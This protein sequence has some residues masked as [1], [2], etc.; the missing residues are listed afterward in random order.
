MNASEERFPADLQL[1]RAD[2]AACDWRGVLAGSDRDGYSSMWQAFSGAA[3]EALEKG[4]QKSSKIFWLLADA[5]S[6]IL[7]PQSKNEPFR[8]HS[9]TEA[10]RSI[11]PDDFTP[12]DIA[13][14]TA[15]VNDI[16]DAWLR[17]R[18]ADLI[19]LK[20]DVR[21]SRFALTAIDAYREI[22][23]D[24]E[25]WMRG[26]E[27]CWYRALGLAK[28]L[29]DTASDR[30]MPMED[31]II[32]AIKG[33]ASGDGFL[34]F[35]LSKLLADFQ[36]GYSASPDIAKDLRNI[37]SSCSGP[38]DFHKAREYLGAAGHWFHIA[39]DDEN[40][41]RMFMEVAENFAKEAYS[42]ETAG[43]PISALAAS[44][45]EE[46]IQACRR[47]PRRLRD[48]LGV[49]KRIS[50]VMVLL[51]SSG[52]LAIG[53][54]QTIRTPEVDITES[55][56]HARKAVSGK[57][58]IDALR[59]FTALHKGANAAR[60]RTQTL[61]NMNTYVFSRLFGSTQFGRDGRVIAKRG[62]YG[63]GGAA[64]DEETVAAEMVKDFQIEMRLV[65]QG[66]ILPALD[67]MHC[68]HRF[69]QRDFIDLARQ[70]PIVPHG[71]A[72]QFG[73]GLFAGYD[74]DFVVAIYL[75]TPQIEQLV[76]FHLQRAGAI[77]T[78]L[79]PSGIET[80]IGLSALIELP[81][82]KRVFGDDLAFEIRAVFCDAFGPNLRN[83]VAHGLLDDLECQSIYSVYAWSLALRIVFNAYWNTRQAET[84]RIPKA[85]ASAS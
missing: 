1:D 44:L 28:N 85:P 5:C 21:D 70:S 52:Q 49:Q 78:K 22:P 60:M 19:W 29:K 71:R 82:T 38:D 81:D 30:L 46:A 12:A 73:R 3:R 65:V 36:L 20:A 17:A 24:L 51:K 61:K 67:V 26:G 83:E 2:L 53:Q 77:T 25:T 18:L 39:K 54:F 4:N 32:V 23:L 66:Y 50:E 47:V 74:C 63:L 37:A 72:V 58:S 10:R 59:C 55:I 15:V 43:T 75:L 27:H 31:A 8:A 6:M 41:A 35:W 45:Y 79:D 80:E 9:T 7:Q 48:T 64:A 34:A 56:E 40:A 14:F 69:S 76:R 62:A 33:A 57:S 11:L 42:K 68:E 13:F 84:E 16:D